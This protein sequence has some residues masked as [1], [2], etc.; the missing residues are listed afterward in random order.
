[1]SASNWASLGDPEALARL[2]AELAPACGGVARGIFLR[3]A[4]FRFLATPS[5]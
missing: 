1:M 5:C 4:R 3:S 2:E